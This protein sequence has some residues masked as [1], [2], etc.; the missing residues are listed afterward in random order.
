MIMFK[1]ALVTLVVVICEVVGRRRLR[2][3]RGLARFAVGITSV[4]VLLSCGQL[5]AF[6]V[7]GP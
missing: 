2:M 1:Y 5:L 4:P 7:V 3:G 6:A